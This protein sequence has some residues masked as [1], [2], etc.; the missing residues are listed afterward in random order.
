MGLTRRPVPADIQS[1]HNRTRKGTVLL[2][3]DDA[4][5]DLIGGGAVVGH[6]GLLQNQGLGGGLASKAD[7]IDGGRVDRDLGRLVV[8]LEIESAWKEET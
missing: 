4:L 2:E 5:D 3:V 7:G 8:E 6:G 1:L